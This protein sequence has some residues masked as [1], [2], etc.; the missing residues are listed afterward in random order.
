M[1]NLQKGFQIATF[2]RAENV[3][4]V[5]IETND[6]PLS[7]NNETNKFP[8]RKRISTGYYASSQVRKRQQA[9]RESLEKI[10]SVK[11]YVKKQ[12]EKYGVPSKIAKIEEAPKTKPPFMSTRK[13]ISGNI[14]QILLIHRDRKEK[15]EDFLYE[16]YAKILSIRQGVHSCEKVV[17]LRNDTGP[18]LPGVFYEIDRKLDIRAGQL[19]RCVGHFVPNNPQNR[20]RLLKITQTDSAFVEFTGRLQA[21]CNFTLKD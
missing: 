10:A 15:E 6:P 20:F 3:A 19:V 4:I 12:T 5:Q 21:I 17:N 13:I 9:K 18:V 8:V 7:G 1:N 11:E 16:F 14:S 2:P